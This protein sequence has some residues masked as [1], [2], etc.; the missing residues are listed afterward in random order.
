LGTA[1]GEDDGVCT[2]NPTAVTGAQFSIPEDDL[3]PCRETG[4]KG[5]DDLFDFG[6]GR[7]YSL[8]DGNFE[9]GL[10]RWGYADF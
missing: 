5:E 6:H 10:R 8:F 2:L 4:M 1:L 3:M 9:L 7:N